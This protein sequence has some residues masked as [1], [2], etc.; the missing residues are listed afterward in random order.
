MPSGRRRLSHADLRGR[1]GSAGQASLAT[2]QAGSV[3]GDGC[4]GHASPYHFHVDLRCEY[5]PSS[6]SAAAA[7]SAHS[8]LVGIALDGRGVYGVWEGPSS[9]TSLPSLD[10]CGGRAGPPR[11]APT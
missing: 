7:V 10:A 5:S 1:C 4:G 2:S 11:F 9:V 3:F 6:S 8:P